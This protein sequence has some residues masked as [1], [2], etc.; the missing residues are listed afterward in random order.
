MVERPWES[1]GGVT[2]PASFPP[3]FWTLLGFLPHSHDPRKKQ[4]TPSD[5][6]LHFL[7][8]RRGPWSTPFPLLPATND[9]I[10]TGKFIGDFLPEF[11]FS[12]NAGRVEMNY[13]ALRLAINALAVPGAAG[14]FSERRG[15][16]CPCPGSSARWRQPGTARRAGGGGW[17]FPRRAPQAAT[18][19]G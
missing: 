4:L 11:P 15:T 14:P 6:A 2:L 3:S 10:G 8:P 1:L 13:T 12:K 9:P 16:R 17:R 18:R 7:P 5:R 19:A